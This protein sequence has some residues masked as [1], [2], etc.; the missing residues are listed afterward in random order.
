MNPFAALGGG[1]PTMPGGGAEASGKAALSPSEKLKRAKDR[2][3]KRKARKQNRK[4]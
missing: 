3:A 2:R 4:K 1:M